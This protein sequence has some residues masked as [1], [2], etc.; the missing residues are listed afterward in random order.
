MRSLLS[1]V[2]ELP[3]GAL[4]EPSG[5][6]SV[7]STLDSDSSPERYITFHSPTEIGSTVIDLLSL[8]QM[9]H[10]PQG[11]RMAEILAVEEGEEISSH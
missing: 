1:I 7:L 2:G 10:S 6:F 8:I 11:I 3:P 9:Y 4:P 5:G